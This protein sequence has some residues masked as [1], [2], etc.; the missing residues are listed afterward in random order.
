[1]IF[2]MKN[3]IYVFLILI[4][5]LVFS[6]KENDERIAIFEDTF[7]LTIMDYLESKKD[8][9]SQFI[10]IIEKGNLKQALSAYNPDGNGYTVFAPDNSAIEK[11]INES[12]QFSSLNDILD[13]P[14]VAASFCR[15]HVVNMK[16]RSNDFPFGAFT[17]PTLSGDYLIVN[18]I[19]EGD[20]AYYK[21]NNQSPVSRPNIETSNGFVHLLSRA[22]E[23]VT[24]T[25][26]KLIEQNPGV[27]IFKEAVDITGLRDSINFN[28]KIDENRL[29]VTVLAEPDTI[30]QK[31]GINSL[32]DLITLISPDNSDYTSPANPLYNYV[33][34][35]ILSG[36]YYIDDFI[37]RNTNY[38]TYSEVPIRIDGRG[39]DI[40]INPGK[41]IFDTLIF[42]GDTTIVNFIK[43]IYDQSNVVSQ[44][45]PIHYI[46]Q[47]MKQYAP[48]RATT[49]YQ[50]YEEPVL[51]NY[52][53]EKGEFLIEEQS[54]NKIT[55]SGADLFYV[56]GEAG[57]SNASNLDY[58]MITGDF[59][60]SYKTPRLVQG[61][62]RV[63]LRA[64]SF[65]SANAVVEVLIDRKKVG[66]M[67][68]LSLGSTPTSPFRN[69][70]LGTIEFSRYAEHDVEIRSLIP[71]RLLWDYIQFEPY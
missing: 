44:S 38:N 25:S 64:E 47:V 7:Q 56:A 13:N 17:E 40:A 31:A 66:G 45:G 2:S 34:Y 60:I 48:S 54:L 41:E 61:R 63:Y 37:N 8:S 1:M 53:Q 5:G 21:I 36:N 11:L 68:D 51:N 42:Q 50:F 30:Y 33:A 57:S 23:P 12:T 18:F 70:E 35:H 22:L 19:L 9:F 10:Q 62:Y 29:A 28:L 59:N 69:I 39:L 52:Y 20:T 16:V 46:D 43:I 27:N 14:S 65:N 26:Y 49:S 4:A 24:F 6:C 67:V 3:S 55:W 58:L 71:G 32:N 15:Y